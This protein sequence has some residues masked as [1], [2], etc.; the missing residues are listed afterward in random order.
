MWPA[1][2]QVAVDP[3]QEAYLEAPVE[4]PGYGVLFCSLEMPR[5]QLASRLLA[6]EA[7]VSMSNIR[8]G[9]VA[10]EAWSKLT[11]AASRLGRLPLWLDDTPRYLAARPPGEDPALAGR[12]QARG[13]AGAGQ[14]P[15]PDRCRLPPAHERQEGCGQPRARDQRAFSRAEAARQRDEGARDG[16]QSAEPLGGDAHDQGQA[17]SA[18]RSAR[19]G[20]HR[21]GRRHHHVHLSRR[22]LLQ[23]QRRQRHGRGDR[24][25]AA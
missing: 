5:E 10:R 23:G 20:R 19:V 13:R 17:P 25:Q 15:R 14:G 8:S 18:F 24:R 12:D 22:V 11:D 16:A 3:N 4:E 2:A 1:R 7:R 9:Q 6:S 21:A